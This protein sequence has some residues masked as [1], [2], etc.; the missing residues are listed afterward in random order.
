MATIKDSVNDH[1][2]NILDHLK[3]LVKNYASILT[4]FLNVISNL[5]RDDL[6]DKIMAIYFR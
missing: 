1:L 5:N 3:D 4:P 2:D 6:N